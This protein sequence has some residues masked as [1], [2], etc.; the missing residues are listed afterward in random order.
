MNPAF[1]DL[2]RCPST[3]SALTLEAT[4]VYPR[5]GVRT[6]LLRGGDRAYPI[7]EGVPRFVGDELYSAS[8]GYEWKRWSRVQFE[9]EN[10]GRAMAGHTTR[11]FDAITGFTGESLRGRMVVDFGCGSGRFLDVVRSRGGVAVGIDL[12]LA[13]ESA[14][15][16]F[17]GDPEVLIVQGDVLN[18][19]FKKGVFDAGYSIGVLHHT[20][21]PEKGFRALVEAVRPGGPVACC[22]YP[23][24][25]FYDY[26]SVRRF[27]RVHN[28]AK[29]FVGNWPA[30]GYSYIAAYGLHYA[31]AVM[32]LVPILGSRTRRFLE[33]QVL[34][35]LSIPDARWRVLDV[36]DAITP[37]HASTHTG[38]EVRKWY[39]TAGL[40]GVHRTPWCATSWVGRRGEPG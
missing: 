18:P 33:R 29:A 31:L 15:A 35:N 36:F 32:G 26:P 20:P 23:K 21:D 38:E 5:G 19:P 14:R 6:G 22:V 37:F 8:F 24:G 4:E 10:V 7:R 11:M 16:N 9:A 28:A 1:M 30:L 3:G 40:R 13:V 17:A 34:V 2:L 27:R 25:E 12:S 39:E